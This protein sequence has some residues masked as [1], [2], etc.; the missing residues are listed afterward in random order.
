V[1]G[2]MSERQLEQALSTFRD[3]RTAVQAELGT[4]GPHRH[5]FDDSAD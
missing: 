2:R 4:S 1:L 3:F 5:H